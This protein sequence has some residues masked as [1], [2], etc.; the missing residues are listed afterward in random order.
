MASASAVSIMQA[1]KWAEE[2]LMVL[3][4]VGVV[5]VVFLVAAG[6]PSMNRQILLLQ[7]MSTHTHP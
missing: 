7:V 4:L 1:V 6:R 3:G 5:V 2:E